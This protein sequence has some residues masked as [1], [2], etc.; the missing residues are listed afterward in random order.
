MYQKKSAVTGYNL[1][2][3]TIQLKINSIYDSLAEY[4]QNAKLI[5]EVYVYDV[6]RVFACDLS[7]SQRMVS[8]RDVK[9]EFSFY[10]FDTQAK[11]FMS[12]L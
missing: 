10:I 7:L 2:Q 12:Q 3:E 5:A 8:V 9:Q 11:I 4:V 1:K 6:V